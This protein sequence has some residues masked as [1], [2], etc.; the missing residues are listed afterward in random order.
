MS[1]LVGLTGNNADVGYGESVTLGVDQFNEALRKEGEDFQIKDILQ[2]SQAIPTV[3]MSL[4]LDAIQNQGA[5]MVIF[6][7]S[8]D[9]VV[10]A[11]S[12]YDSDPSNDLNVVLMDGLGS[13]AAIN[14]HTPGSQPWQIDADNWIWRTVMSSTPAA[15]TA[16]D[17]LGT[18]TPAGHIPG[19]ING[20]GVVKV[21]MFGTND[22][23]GQPLVADA[24]ARAK[25]IFGPDTVIETAFHD[26]GASVD[27]S[28]IW[29][30]FVTKL[31]DANDD[32]ASGSTPGNVPDML[33]AGLQVLYNVP[34]WKAYK[35][36]GSPA[37]FMGSLAMRSP[38]FL[39]E[40][41]ALAE[42][43][44]QVGFQQFANNDAGA[45]YTADF[46][47]AGNSGGSAGLYDAAVLSGLAAFIAAQATGDIDTVGNDDIKAALAQTSVEG[48]VRAIPGVEGIRQALRAIKAGQAINYDGASGPLDF[49]AYGDVRS[50]LQ[51]SVVQGGQWVTTQSFDCTESIDSCPLVQ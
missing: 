4:A 43:A 37:P 51:K 6:D 38:V 11:Q 3:A 34:T 47:A 8:Q 25:A 16:I 13:G 21:A 18:Y 31:L 24:T 7:T 49:D 12:Y 22:G 35:A 9:V 15:N 23:L 10:A 14:K 41:G 5:R 39:S 42:G 17:V 27:D 36:T 30:N 33:F 19:D 1:A 46:A 45:K 28:T 2:D 48:G 40:V 26:P 50:G 32:T 44:Q 29:T 20:D